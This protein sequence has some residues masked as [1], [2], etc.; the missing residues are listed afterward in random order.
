MSLRGLINPLNLCRNVDHEAVYRDQ[1]SRGVF[2]TV[3]ADGTINK[4][5]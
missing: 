1:V 3:R 5:W 2:S 4:F